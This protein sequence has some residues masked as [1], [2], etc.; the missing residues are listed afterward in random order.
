MATIN[1]RLLELEKKIK[2]VP[3]SYTGT[4]EESEA[5]YRRLVSQSE[6]SDMTVKIPDDP[7]SASSAYLKLIHGV[8]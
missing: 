7:I 1:N 4:P 6:N 5:A 8:D 2:P 3:E